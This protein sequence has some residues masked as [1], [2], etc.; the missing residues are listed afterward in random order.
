MAKEQEEKYARKEAKAKQA[1]ELNELFKPV[2]EQKVGKGT[3]SR[4]TTPAWSA[5]GVAELFSD[6][7]LVEIELTVYAPV[8]D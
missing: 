2:I 6:A 7:G 1:L 4:D 5:I 8:D 3:L